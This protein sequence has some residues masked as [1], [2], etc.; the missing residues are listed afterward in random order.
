M[1]V[2]IYEIA[3]KAG[4]SS[5]TVARVLR[6]DVKGTS[7][8]SAARVDEIRQLAEKMGYRRNW[9]A[10][11]FSRCKTHAIGLFH[12]HTAWISEGTMGEISGAFNAAMHDLG[13]HV[14]V[15]QYDEKGDWKELLSDGRFDGIAISHYV[16]PEAQKVINDLGLPRVLLC[17]KSV[18]DW[19]CVATEDE[20]GA[21]T[22]TKHFISLGHRRIAMYQNDTIREHFS[23]GERH[24]GYRR[25]LKEAGLEDEINEWSIPETKLPDLLGDEANRPTAIL[26]YCHEEAMAVYLTAWRLGLRIPDDLSVIG[27]NDLQATRYMTPP[28]TTIGFGTK[29]IGRVGAKLLVRQI[30]S[31][32][33]EVERI[34]IAQRLIERESTAPPRGRIR[35]V[36]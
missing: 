5:S 36:K 8:R 32:E 19:P 22:A 15:V 12:T 24:E 7:Q 25:A 11:A 20:V 4:V 3:E 28:L 29:H 1:A 9:R 34:F 23:V 18:P 27:F 10:R 33:A 17:D 35:G 21:Y 26:C 2:T 13:Y 16:P 6:G 31:E 30:E 14:V